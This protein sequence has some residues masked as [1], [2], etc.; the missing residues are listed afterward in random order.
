[1]GSCSSK[2]TVAVIIAS[3]EGEAEVVY[4][5]GGGEGGEGGG[6]GDGG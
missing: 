5:D 2:G 4:E 1:M 6:E 3:F